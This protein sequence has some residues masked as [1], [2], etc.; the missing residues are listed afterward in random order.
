LCSK[1]VSK[2]VTLVEQVSVIAEN[3]RA[4]DMVLVWRP[5]HEMIFVNNNKNQNY[6]EVTPVST[7]T[8]REYIILI[9]TQ[10]QLASKKLKSSLLDEVVKNTC[11]LI[12]DKLVYKSPVSNISNQFY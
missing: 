9:W 3:Y 6:S 7:Q 10:Y 8:V 12:V 1:R 2:R 5:E 11:T 4:L